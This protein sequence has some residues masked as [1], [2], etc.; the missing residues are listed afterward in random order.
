MEIGR[1]LWN[2]RMW[3]RMGESGILTMKISVLQKT[4]VFLEQRSSKSFWRCYVNTIIVFLD[5]IHWPI[6]I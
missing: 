6:F 3:L 2:A 4:G 5:I 1:Q